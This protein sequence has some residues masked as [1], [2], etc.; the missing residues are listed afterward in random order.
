[1]VPPGDK[2]I[3]HRSI[4]LGGIAEGTTVVRGLLE[5]EDVLATI[6]ALRAMGAKIAKQGEEWHITGVGARGL[7]PPQDILDMGNSGTSARLLTGLIAGYP[8]SA[9]ITGDASLRKRPMGRVIEPLSRMGAIFQSPDGKLPLTVTGSTP[10]IAMT[11][12]LPVAS[13]Q[14][15]SAILLAGLG[16]DGVT[17]VIEKIPTRDHSENMLRGFGAEVTVTKREDGADIISIR[18]KAKLTAQRISVPADPSSAAFPMV[19]ALLVPG[20][21]I[22]LRNVG[23]NPRRAGL[24]EVL[25]EMGGDITIE[26]RHEEGGEAVG[27]LRVRGSSLRGI[28]VPAERAPS[29]IDEYTVLSVA[30]ACAQGTTRMLGLHELRVKESDRLA[31]M[32]KGLTACGVKLEVEG[33][34]LIVHGTGKPPAG[35]VTVETAMDHRIAMSFLVLGTVSAQPVSID[36]GSFITTSFPGFVGMMNGLGAKIAASR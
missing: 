5:G 31:V 17:T 25:I 7:Q 29:M 34:D 11:Y 22:V 1:M 16:A 26:N 9:H 24:I 12:E 20:S 18:G 33:D 32:A 3:S 35:G 15:K 21:D 28:M 27:D 10:L 19:A 13:A 14:V 36:D 6:A 8:V 2:S 23:L 30:A 4:M